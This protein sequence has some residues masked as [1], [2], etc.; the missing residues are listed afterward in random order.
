MQLLETKWILMAIAHREH[1]P[2]VLMRLEVHVCDDN[3]F[4]LFRQERSFTV[5]SQ[6]EFHASVD[7]DKSADPV[8]FLQVFDV[9]HT[10][11][12][13]AAI[14]DSSSVDWMSIVGK[15]NVKNT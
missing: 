10:Y 15:R 14:T 4:S 12:H 3:T 11:L 7:V 6:W 2:V 9:K 1:V 13:F 5:N 8:V